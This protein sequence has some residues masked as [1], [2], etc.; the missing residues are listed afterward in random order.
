MCVYAHLSGGHGGQK[1]ALELES[2]MVWM[3]VSHHVW[4]L[5]T[6]PG[7]LQQQPVLLP[8]GHLCS[9]LNQVLTRTTA[10]AHQP[11]VPRRLSQE[12]GLSQ[13]SSVTEQVRAQAIG[14]LV[15]D[16]FSLEENYFKTL[17]KLKFK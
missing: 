11:P 9:L 4:V 7:S 13:L 10:D 5:V 1:R 3:V 15:S 14:G 2:R 17:E 8:L 12:D 6:E 16:F